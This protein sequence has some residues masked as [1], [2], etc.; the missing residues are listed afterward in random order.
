MGLKDL[1]QE[2]K[3]EMSPIRWRMNCVVLPMYVLSVLLCSGA[4][5]WL[6][7]ASEKNAALGA[8]IAIPLSLFVLLTVAL[9]VISGVVVKKE[10]EI[11][12]GRWAFL[13]DDD[14]S[15]DGD[16]LETVD[17]ETGIQFSL[18][19]SGVKI[20]YPTKSEQ[21]FAEVEDNVKF[22]RWDDTELI[23]ATDNYLRRVR[24]AIA[25]ADVSARSVDG[26]YEPQIDDIYFLPLCPNLSALLRTFNVEERVSPEWAYLKYNQNEAIAQILSFGYIKKFKAKK[27]DELA[28]ENG[29]LIIKQGE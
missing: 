18:S 7:I 19:Q 15:F 24:L 13:F 10:I 17:V 26:E 27:G 16:E 14:A 2:E 3:R 28:I 12:K 25:M 23:L 1:W 11:E 29:R 20:I 9:L 21:V 8:F 6:G 4:I 5:V 22:L